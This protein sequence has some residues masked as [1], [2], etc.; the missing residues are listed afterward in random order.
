MTSISIHPSL[1]EISYEFTPY[2]PDTSMQIRLVNAVTKTMKMYFNAQSILGFKVVFDIQHGDPETFKSERTI[3]I[4]AMSMYWCQF[5]YQYA[6]EF[7]HLLIPEPVPYHFK[8]FE[9]SLCDLSSIFFLKVLRDEWS[10]FFPEYASYTDAVCSYISSL[11][12]GTAFPL[13][14]LSVPDSQTYLYLSLNRYDRGMNRY[15]S[16]QMLPI[17]EAHPDIWRAVPLL[18]KVS[19]AQSFKD[20]LLHWR[21]ISGQDCIDDIISLIKPCG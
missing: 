5:I 16:M 17:F 10:S 12:N 3:Y 6:H 14:S 15:F 21:N 1:P 19:D 4:T 11:S 13:N 20:Y 18:H 7:C 8:W 9:E 2:I